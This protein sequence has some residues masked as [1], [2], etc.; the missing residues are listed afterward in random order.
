MSILTALAV[1]G[2]VSKVGQGVLGYMAQ[3]KKASGERAANALQRKQQEYATRR[4]R[5]SAIREAQIR[6]A[7]TMSAAGSAGALGGSAIS[8]G[9]GSLASQLGSG[10]GY[11]SLQ[12]SI[13]GDIYNIQRSTNSSLSRLAGI[14]SIFGALGGSATTAAS[15]MTPTEAPRPD[16]QLQRATASSQRQPNARGRLS[17][18]SGA[19]LEPIGGGSNFLGYNFGGY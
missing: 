8:G 10:L 12:S 13:S 6:R 15:F 16:L 17:G 2:A 1:V 7:Q 18:A 19:A 9:L 14:S 4:Q 5:R 11:S 3:R